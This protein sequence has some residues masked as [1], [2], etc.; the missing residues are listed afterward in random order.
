MNNKFFKYKILSYIINLF[1]IIGVYLIINYLVQTKIIN[2]YY[3]GILIVTLINIILAVSLNLTTGFLGELALGHAG[4]MAVGAYAGAIFTKTMVDANLMVAEAAFPI[5]ILLAGVV[6]ALFGLLIGIP[7]LRLKGDYLAIITLGFGE[8]IRILIIN[9]DITGGARG[10][11]KIPR[12]TTIGYAY[13]IMVAFIIIMF[14][15][16]RSR[17]GR[18]IL[19]IRE[20]SIAAEASGIPTVYYKVYAFTLAAFFAGIAGALYAHYSGTLDPKTFGFARS[21]EILVMVVLGGMGSITG[22]VVS[23]SVLTV[24]PEV[25]RG[26]SEYRMLVYSLALIIMMLFR[27]KGLLGTHEVSFASMVLK[28]FMK[29]E[30]TDISS[31]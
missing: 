12:V 4:F 27:P 23:A 22:S 13:F 1:I 8:I 17:H 2:R 28:P 29:R 15:I 20:D 7:V 25:L 5:S 24:L 19:S 21:I 9:L 14:T 10:L 18:A 26:F 3:Q 11:T 16:G 30:K 31:K 6:A